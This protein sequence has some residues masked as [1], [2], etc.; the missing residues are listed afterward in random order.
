MKGIQ[1]LKLYKE[2]ILKVSED[3]YHTEFVSWHADTVFNSL[4]N[5]DPFHMPE[6]ESSGRPIVDYTGMLK[7][8]FSGR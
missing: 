6:L 8:H 7:D 5:P 1:T 2:A 4:Q 3:P